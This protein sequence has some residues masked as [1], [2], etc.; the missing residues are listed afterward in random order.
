LANDD[1]SSYNYSNYNKRY[2]NNVINNMSRIRYINNQ[3]NMMRDTSNYKTD[4]I[5]Y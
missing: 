3:T 4:R 1:D 5:S 2:N